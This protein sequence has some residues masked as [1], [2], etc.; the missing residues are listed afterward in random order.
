MR[1]I[2]RGSKKL[3]FGSFL[4]SDFYIT[5]IL[6]W[7]FPLTTNH[8][9]FDFIEFY[10]N[11]HLEWPSRESEFISKQRSCDQK[12]RWISR[13]SQRSLAAGNRIVCGW[14]ATGHAH[15]DSLKWPKSG[16]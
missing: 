13:R 10:E 12:Q 16:C 1:G 5:G 9:Q 11:C 2:L 7:I 8:N 14:I 3:L 6:S 15:P 4:K